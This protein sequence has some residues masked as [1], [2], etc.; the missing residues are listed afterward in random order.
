MRK[1][2]LALETLRVESFDTAERP[3]ARGTVQGAED[4]F[5]ADCDTNNAW[6]TYQTNEVSCGGTCDC[7]T[8]GTRITEC[9]TCFYASCDG[10]TC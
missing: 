7:G 2:K 10:Y 1:L 6:C 8:G 3:E 9:A 4:T 5:N